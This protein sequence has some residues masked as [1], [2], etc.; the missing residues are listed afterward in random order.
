MS[1]PAKRGFGTLQLEGRLLF[2]ALQLLD[3]NRVQL[4]DTVYDRG[5]GE[6]LAAAQFLQDTV[7]SYLRL[8][9]LRALSMF[10][11]SLIGMIIMV[12]K[13]FA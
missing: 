13:F 9:F 12:C 3:V 5:F 7:F 4:V 10:S 11:P 6:V 1:W 8:N 2:F